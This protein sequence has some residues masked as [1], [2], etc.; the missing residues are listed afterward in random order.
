MTSL[1]ISY[2]RKDMESARKLTDAF[3]GQNL[4]FWVDW[5]GIPPTVDWWKEIERGIEESGIFLFLISP[6]SAKSKVCKQ[7]IEH[8]AKNGKRLIPVVVRDV[9]AEEAPTELGHLNW[10]FLRENDDFNSSFS[11]LLT[12]IRTDF[13]WVQAHRQLQIK[14]L[15]WERSHYENSFFLRGKELQDAE[16]ELAT[17]S[18]KEPRPTDVQREYVLKSRQASDK[19]RRNV[20]IIAIAGVIALAALAVFGFVQAGL[21]T[22]NAS[23][24]NKQALTAQAASTLAI[25]NQNLAEERAKIARAGELTAQ[26]AGLRDS[27]FELSS[28]LG[29]EAFNTWDY[30]RTRSILVNN[31]NTNPQL[32]QYM[33]KHSDWVSTVAF[34]PKGDIVASGGCLKRE[35]LSCSK[36]EIVLWSLQNGELTQNISLQAHNSAVISVVFNPSGTIL[37]S[38]SCSSYEAGFCNKGEIILWDMQTHKPI[39]EPLRGHSDQVNT[40]AFS[41]DGKILASGSCSIYT[42]FCYEGEIILWDIESHTQIG[43]PIHGHTAWVGDIAFSP[44]GKILASGG[45]DG[46][47]LFWDI[48]NNQLANPIISTGTDSGIIT[49]IEFSPD[50]KVLVSGDTDNKLILWDTSNGEKIQELNTNDT[51]VRD[52]DIYTVT[53]SPDG[54]ILASGRSDGKIFLWNAENGNS[55]NVLQGHSGIVTSLSF[56]PDGKYLVSASQDSKVILWDISNDFPLGKLVT[57]KAFSLWNTTFDING[58][59]VVIEFKDQALL[60]SDL[61]SNLHIG[62]PITKYPDGA[63]SLALSADNSKLAIGSE[64]SIDLWDINHAQP[65]PNTPITGHSGLISSLAF[66]PDGKILVSGG[67]QNRDESLVCHSGKILVWDIASGQIVGEPIVGHSSW[68][69]SLAISP[70]NQL[71]ASGSSDGNILLWNLSTHQTI[72]IPL[73]S[74]QGKIDSVAFSP[75]GKM[76]ASGGNDGSIILWDV[77]TQKS[78]IDPLYKGIGPIDRLSFSPDG[79]QLI[80]ADYYNGK[81]MLW[82]VDPDNWK[83]KTCQRIGRNITQEE[84]ALY[85]PGEAYRTTCPQWP[86]GD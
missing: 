39:G 21:A 28:L 45:G 20:T 15:E 48:Q 44:D 51:D 50:G 56:S 38:G 64:G 58:K 30:F 67:C 59:V 62:K 2:S 34:S 57:N 29:V 77:E 52:H 66:S 53:F 41:P 4:D 17:N 16:R 24:A 69:N 35:G 65:L 84:W 60:V 14:A 83:Q 32:R 68:V 18:S 61:Q 9:K 80:S 63:S 11:K 31:L 74:H 43:S 72:G 82:E 5:E 10:I 70:D 46:K 33:I 27:N 86:T 19:Q 54:K 40:L 71:L 23:E 8:A 25:N 49:S 36:G 12:A 6:D 76:L 3:K 42:G 1:F 7:E 26:S 37:A 73:I 22:A 75:D 79:Q 85:F 81:I 47:I 78:I 13:G 55:I